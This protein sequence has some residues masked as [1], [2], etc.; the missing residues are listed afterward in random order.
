VYNGKPLESFKNLSD[1]TQ[2]TLKKTNFAVDGE[3]ESKGTFLSGYLGGGRLVGRPSSTWNH[4]RRKKIVMVA[5]LGR[6]I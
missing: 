5:P 1:R 6:E 3:V 2:F 4:Q